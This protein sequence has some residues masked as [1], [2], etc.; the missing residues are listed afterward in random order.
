MYSWLWKT[1]LLIPQSTCLKSI[2]EAGDR[3][4]FWIFI[5]STCCEKVIKCTTSLTFYLFSSIRIT[6]SIL[7]ELSV[8][9]LYVPGR[10]MQWVTCLATGV[11]D[12]R[13]RGRKFY[14]GP[15]PYFRGDWSWNNFYGRCPLFR[16]FIQEW[17]LSVTSESIFTNYWLTAC[18]SLPRK[19]VWL[20][21]L[22]E[23]TVQPW[24]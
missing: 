13:S 20:G 18:S 16:W 1:Q 11:S 22:T 2:R 23:L 17:L 12:C 10:V 19:K 24:P 15:V 14:P 8:W 9:I 7:H 3:L 5:I 4:Y 6:N 21:E